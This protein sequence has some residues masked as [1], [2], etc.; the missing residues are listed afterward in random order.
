MSEGV[1]VY[2][3]RLSF[4]NQDPMWHHGF[5]IE[6]EAPKRE[7][8]R[9]IVLYHQKSKPHERA[10]LIIELPDIGHK[11]LTFTFDRGHCFDPLGAEIV[12]YHAP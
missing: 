11:I 4:N 10:N 8:H 6:G 5:D 9:S 12:P 7:P 2:V 3:K 1:F